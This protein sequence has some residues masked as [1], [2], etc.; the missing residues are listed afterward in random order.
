MP[1]KSKNFLDHANDK[2]SVLADKIAPQVESAVGTAREKAGPLLTEAREKA[3]P[4]V[5]DAREKFTSDVLP[6][7]TAAIAAAG[8]A[9]EDVR[10]ESKKRGKAAVAALKGEVEAPKKKKH[11]FR[12]FLLV[13]GLGGVVAFVAKKLSDRP[14]TTT[15]EST[16]TPAPAPAAPAGAH[17]AETTEG[18]DQGGAS[19]DVA[20][21]DA[22]AEPHAATTP[23]NPAETIDVKKD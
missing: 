1:K 14:S 5:H 10:G 3:A 12:K 2:A 20:A 18:N 15:W 16:P 19:P 4:A 9:T 17:K 8:E 6:V 21:A 7:I 13:L 11:R 22:A 23:D